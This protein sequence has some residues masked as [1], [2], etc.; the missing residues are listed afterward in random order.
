MANSI[1]ATATVTLEA[2]PQSQTPIGSWP[3]QDTAKHDNMRPNAPI[4]IDVSYA[5]PTNEQGGENP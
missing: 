5:P 3:N 2:I 4:E 1:S